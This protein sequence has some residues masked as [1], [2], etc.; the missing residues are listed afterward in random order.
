MNNE[1]ISRAESHVMDWFQNAEAFCRPY[2]E[3]FNMLFNVYLSK[4]SKYQNVPKSRRS[5][6][7]PPYAFQQV[8]TMKPQILETIF[9][10]QPYLQ[11]VGR[12]PSDMESAETYS[13]YIS[14]QLDEADMYTKFEHLEG[15]CLIYG[16]CVAKIP[17][18]YETENLK[19]RAKIYDEELGIY[20]YKTIEEEVVTY[21]N[22]D[23]QPIPITD[24]F[25]DWRATD[26]NVQK[27]DCAHRMYKSFWDLKSNEKKKDDYGEDDGVYINLSKLEEAI[28]DCDKD[29]ATKATVDGFTEMK[30]EAL[31]QTSNL[32][33]LDKIT[34]IEWWGMFSEKPGQE[35][36]PYVISIAIDYGIV[37]R[38]EANPIPGKLKPFIASPDYRVIGEFYGQGEVEICLSLIQEATALRNARLDQTNLALNGM[39]IVDRTAGINNRSLYSN[40]GGI[41]WANDINGIREMP[42][43]DATNASYKEIGHIE[44]DIQN[45]TANISASQGS[46]NIGRAFGKTATGV[47]Y[48]KKF[49][50]DR[51][52]TKIKLQEDYLLKPLLNL[53]VHYNREFVDDDKVVRVTGKPGSF[54]SLNL[55]DFHRQYDYKRIAISDKIMKA[56]QQNNL[57]MVFQTLMPFIQEFPDR[58]NINNLLGDFLKAFNF[59]D[60]NRYFNQ[61]GNTPLLPQQQGG[62]NEE[63]QQGGG[64]QAGNV[65]GGLEQGVGGSPIIAGLGIQS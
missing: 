55:E 49:T 11:L 44:Y 29:P 32:K 39:Y 52:A 34:V 13:E 48:F 27:F 7:K 47:E 50:S 1:K 10:E 37:I 24:F 16:T 62:M 40:P 63:A 31:D 4:Q 9:S 28:L 26:S 51:L 22:I 14:Q 64:S 36:E 15:H 12:E 38:C 54:S 23:I 58:F 56:E 65:A 17:W 3:K 30:A 20:N 43:P 41:I 2:F 59:K 18:L 33:G 46:A 21:D 6:L 61:N 8:E 42:R 60:V 5:D 45:T 57:S 35:P 53:I 19:R 25:P